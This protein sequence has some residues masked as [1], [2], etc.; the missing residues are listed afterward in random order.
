M[1]FSEVP[2][3]FCHLATEAV[4]DA[5]VRQNIKRLIYI[6]D[7]YANLPV[8]DNYGL[9]EQIHMDIPNSFILGVYGESKTRAEIYARK[10]AEK[11]FYYKFIK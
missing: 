4:V 5:V 9:S 10:A 7:A 6:S 8:G 11:G 3:K 2:Q 1:T